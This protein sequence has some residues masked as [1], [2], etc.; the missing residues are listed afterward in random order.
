MKRIFKYVLTGEVSR[1][2]VSMPAM[3]SVIHFAVQDDKFCIWAIVDD[4]GPV[5]DRTFWVRPTGGAVV[6]G[7][8]FLFTTLDGPFVWH[9]FEAI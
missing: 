6:E 1:S 4:E 5:G 3:A 8:Y 9:L 7:T 2:I